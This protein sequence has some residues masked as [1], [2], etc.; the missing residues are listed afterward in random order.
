MGSGE[1]GK[2]MNVPIKEIY[3]FVQQQFEKKK[4]VTP[5]DEFA[6]L[7]YLESGHVDS[8]G[9]MSFLSAVENRFNIE[10]DENDI[11]SSEFRT[12]GGLVSIIDKKLHEMKL[13]S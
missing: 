5:S 12:V 7:R 2:T 1:S 8:L 11:M 10:I 4:P 6:S 9:L 3:T 13:H